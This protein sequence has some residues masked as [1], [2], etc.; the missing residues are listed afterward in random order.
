[1]IG[2]R[3][4]K[5]AKA[6]ARISAVNSVDYEFNFE[7]AQTIVVNPLALAGQLAAIVNALAEITGKAIPAAIAQSVASASVSATH[8]AIAQD[9]Q[10]AKN[11]TVL[12]GLHA[13]ANPRFAAIRSLAN[14]IAERGP[15]GLSVC[16]CQQR[17]CLAGRGGSTSRSSRPSSDSR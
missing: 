11:A 8:R 9:L 6:G 16:R 1:M 13:M 17:R 3:L 10:Q 2:H 15:T 5:A 4:R 12:I 7:L 14:A